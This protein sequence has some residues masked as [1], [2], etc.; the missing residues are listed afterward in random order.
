MTT[1]RTLAPADREG[2]VAFGEFE[3]WYRITGEPSPGVAPLVVLHGGPGCVHDYVLTIADL[4]QRT[5]HPVIHYDQLGNGRSTRLPDRGADFWTP[6]LFL[7]ELDSLLAGL[8]VLDGYHLLGQ[9]WG[10]MLGAEHAVRRPAGLR[11]LT[12]ADSPASMELWVAE[13]NRLRALLPPEVRATLLAH[14]SDGSYDHP[15]YQRAME[16]FYDRHVCRVVPN[17]PEVAATFAAIEADPTVYLTMNGPTEF[18][19]IGTLRDWTIIDRLDRMAVPTLVVSGAHDEATEACVRP[20]TERIPDVRQHVFPDSS[21]MPHVEERAA[22]MEL[23][24]G[25]LAEVEGR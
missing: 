12:I 18:H 7:A 17:P 15:E 13:A 22:F 14:E 11:S 8:G 6:E 3:T 24:A 10:G 9:S 16:V 21:H 2:T 19:V 20:F 1:A 4:A 5:C 23:L 25:F